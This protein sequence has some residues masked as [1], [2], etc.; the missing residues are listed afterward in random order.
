MLEGV[1]PSGFTPSRFFALPLLWQAWYMVRVDW[2]AP[3]EPLLALNT[4]LDISRQETNGLQ[5]DSKVSHQ[6]G[7]LQ[8]VANLDHC[9]SGLLK[10]PLDNG[11]G[12][13]P[14]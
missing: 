10:A 8:A 7:R 14:L 3:D 11:W 2:S 12:N 1:T 6:R 5:D 4:L 13:E 9:R